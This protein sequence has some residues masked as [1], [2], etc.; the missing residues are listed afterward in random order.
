M[1]NNQICASCLDFSIDK[2]VKSKEDR[3]P[4]WLHKTDFVRQF[5]NNTTDFR[6]RTPHNYDVVL[7]LHLGKRHAGK[8]MLYWAADK[9]KNSNFKIEDARKAYNN[10]ENSGITSID[11][12]GDV[13]IKFCCPQ[14]YRTKKTVSSK[15]HTY[16]RHLHFV[17]SD[18][19]R[20]KWNF[21]IYTKIVVCKYDFAK[22][23]D[24][25]T[26][27]EA[28]LLNT[29]PSLYYDNEHIPDSH[30]LPHETIKHMTQ[31]QIF[32]WISELVLENYPKFN[33]SL[34]NGKLE[35]KELP[36]IT[37]CAHKKCNSSHI[38]LEELLKKGFVNV[39]EYEGGMRDYKRRM[40]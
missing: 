31:K 33:K 23:I 19:K 6:N 34:S 22:T 13:T 24:L 30:N 29:L 7:K 3:K 10:F 21:Q 27:K 9:K 12:N 35:I 1:A 15:P 11:K 17:V 2:V 36:I 14:V 4:T 38:A 8:K 39:N 5:I 26:K 40:L 28:I 37:Y 25:H 18:E 16:F 32:D 20:S